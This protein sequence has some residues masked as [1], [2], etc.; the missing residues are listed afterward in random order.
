M[1]SQ[2]PAW[3]IT[4]YRLPF[5]GDLPCY[6]GFIFLKLSSPLSFWLAGFKRFAFGTSTIWVPKGKIKAVMD[7]VECLRSRDAEMF[8][9]FTK[10]QKLLIYYSKNVKVD[11]LCGFLFGLHERYVTLGSEAVASYIVQALML[12][13]A[14]P[15]ANQHRLNDRQRAALKAAPRLTLEWMEKQSF[16]PRLIKS[17]LGAVE[18]WEQRH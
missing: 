11:N 2:P 9:R 13:D 3:L 14:S 8:L 10:K 6:A 1:N 16:D 5:I 15:S 17:W 12:S 4:I 7:G 18:R